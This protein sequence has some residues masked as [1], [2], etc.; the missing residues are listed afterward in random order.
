MARKNIETAETTTVTAGDFADALTTIA[1]YFYEPVTRI[2]YV[3][4]L[5]SNG[6]PILRSNGTVAMTRQ[7]VEDNALKYEQAAL[8]RNIRINLQ[9]QHNQQADY[10]TAQRFKIAELLRSNDGTEIPM[11]EIRKEKGKLETALHRLAAIDAVLHHAIDAYDRNC[12]QPFEM[13]ERK[14]K[15]ASVASTDSYEQELAALAQLGID[16]PKVA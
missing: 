13:P 2:G 5:D 10:V 8:L 3:P 15:A 14:A 4:Q 6:Q 11:V 16:V 9:M 12:E 7:P 1:R